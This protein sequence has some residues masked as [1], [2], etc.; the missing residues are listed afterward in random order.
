M[1]S[2]N[3]QADIDRCKAE[4]DYRV[5]IKAEL[6]IELLHQK[7]DE[8]REKEVLSLVRAVEAL[9]ARLESAGPAGTRGPDG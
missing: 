6:E 2:Q 8:L 4:D 1:M 9:T 5:N 7:L 3:R